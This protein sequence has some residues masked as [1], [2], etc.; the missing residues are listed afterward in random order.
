MNKTVRICNAGADTHRWREVPG[1]HL[2]DD[3]IY[4]TDRHLDYEA[5]KRPA[6]S[7]PQLSLCA[8]LPDPHKIHLQP[9]VIAGQS[10]NYRALYNGPGHAPMNT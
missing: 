5:N 2:A 9:P 10:A 3:E 8:L 1:I 6:V 7:V 4:T